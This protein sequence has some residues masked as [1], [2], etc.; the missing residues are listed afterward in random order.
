MSPRKL[1]SSASQ[2]RFKTASESKFWRCSCLQLRNALH[3]KRFLKNNVDIVEVRRLRQSPQCSEN[4]FRSVSA[5]ALATEHCFL[6][7]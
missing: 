2:Q 1:S 6:S 4:Y 5:R 3:D 7:S